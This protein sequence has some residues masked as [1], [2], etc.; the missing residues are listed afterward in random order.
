MLSTVLGTDQ[1]PTNVSCYDIDAAAYNVDDGDCDDVAKQ[2]FQG[3]N[4]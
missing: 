1:W 4:K 3:H 2:T